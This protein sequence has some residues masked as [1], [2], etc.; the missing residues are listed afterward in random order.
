MLGNVVEPHNLPT[1]ID[2]RHV[3]AG[4][5]TANEQRAAEHGLA[6]R[7]ATC[8][9]KLEVR[10]LYGAPVNFLSDSVVNAFLRGVL[11][12]FQRARFPLRNGAGERGFAA[13]SSCLFS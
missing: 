11:S 12:F 8:A 2:V 5:Y 7:H 10:G 3:Y 6:F 1:C 4:V 9:T 13:A